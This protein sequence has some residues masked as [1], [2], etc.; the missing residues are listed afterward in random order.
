VKNDW[1][2]DEKVEMIGIANE[3]FK[4]LHMK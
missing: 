4:V 1:T 2:A 3:D